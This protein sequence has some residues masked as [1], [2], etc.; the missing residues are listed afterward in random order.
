V[1]ILLCDN[2]RLLVEALAAALRRGGHDVVATTTQPEEAMDAAAEH[3]PDV[4]L[5]DM[6]FPGDAGIRTIAGIRATT[7][8]KVLVL[9]ARCDQ[10]AVCA[11][12]AAGAAGFVGKDQTIEDIFRSL[13]QVCAGEVIM[14]PVDP[15]GPGRRPGR[16]RPQEQTALRFLTSREREALRLIA[17]GESTKEIAQSMHVAY[18]TA[19]THVQNVLTKLGVRSRLQAA[20][21]VAR[22][23]GAEQLGDHMIVGVTHVDGSANNRSRPSATAGGRRRAASRQ[24]HP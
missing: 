9:S 15:V 23:S 1:R 19:R 12:L 17:E 7:R 4:C 21:L 24:L 14:P 16:L 6:I 8:S 22:A 2:H 20:A 11:A 5:L 3:D 10:D 18:S 13:E